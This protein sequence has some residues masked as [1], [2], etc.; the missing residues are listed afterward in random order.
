[1]M[2]IDARDCTGIAPGL[3]RDCTGIAPG[4]HRDCTSPQTGKG[5]AWRRKTIL[6][7]Q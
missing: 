1:L 2:K 3:H 7:S 6:P 5:T 4:L